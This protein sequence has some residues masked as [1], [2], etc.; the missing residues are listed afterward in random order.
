M[1][2]D[3]WPEPEPEPTRRAILAALAA[4]PVAGGIVGAFARIARHPV[5][6]EAARLSARAFLEPGRDVR[7][8]PW[9][10]GHDVPRDRRDVD[11]RKAEN[12]QIRH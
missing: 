11:T 3:D 2:D 12:R 8:F 9:Q 4:L 6:T 5:E 1:D 7:R 10:A